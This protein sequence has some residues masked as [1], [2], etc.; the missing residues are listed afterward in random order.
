MKGFGFLGMKGLGLSVTARDSEAGAFSFL[1]ASR[2]GIQG[3][4]LLFR[5]LE[6]KTSIFL[7]LTLKGLI[8]FKAFGPKDPI[9]YIGLWGYSDAK[10]SGKKKTSNMS[11]AADGP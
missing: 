8:Y 5:N 1:M 2:T 6:S 3:S 4:P 10:G 9:T 11:F 7:P